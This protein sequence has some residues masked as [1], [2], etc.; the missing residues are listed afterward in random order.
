MPKMTTA[1]R[2]GTGHATTA[3]FHEEDVLEEARL[4]IP[5]RHRPHGSR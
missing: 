3:G 5:F 2:H 1:T 4:W